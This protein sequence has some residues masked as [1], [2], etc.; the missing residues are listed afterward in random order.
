MPPA[1]HNE[2]TLIAKMA[3]K[4]AV[5]ETFL[6][7]G[8]DTKDPISV[9]NQFATLRNIHYGMRHVRNVIIAGVLGA[10]VSGAVWAF[11]TGFKASAAAPSATISAPGGSR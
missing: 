10:I 3:A 8:L 4:E 6:T 5:S 9:Q 7:L 11:W 2:L 1:Q